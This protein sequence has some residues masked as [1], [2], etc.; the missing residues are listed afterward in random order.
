MAPTPVIRLSARATRDSARAA[1][2]S[3]GRAGSRSSRTPATGE[4]AVIGTH[5]ARKT[6]ATAQEACELW[7]TRFARAIMA[8]PSPA[9]ITTCSVTAQAEY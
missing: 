9:E 2:T 8:S 4:S 1:V 7:K 3:T 6:A 5:T